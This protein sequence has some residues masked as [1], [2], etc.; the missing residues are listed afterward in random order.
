MNQQKIF[1]YDEELSLQLKLHRERFELTLSIFAK[2]YIV[3]E[4]RVIHADF[5]DMGDTVYIAYVIF[6]GHTNI[7]K[8]AELTKRTGAVRYDTALYG[9]F[10]NPLLMWF[11]NECLVFAEIYTD[12]SKFCCIRQGRLFDLSAG[13]NNRLTSIIDN[14]DSLIAVLDCDHFA[15]QTEPINGGIMPFDCTGLRIKRKPAL[16]T[17]R[18]KNEDE[19]GKPIVG[20]EKSDTDAFLEGGS[21]IVKLVSFRGYIYAAYMRFEKFSYVIK[22]TDFGK[23]QVVVD[24]HRI[25]RHFDMYIDESTKEYVVKSVDATYRKPVLGGLELEFLVGGDCD[26][27]DCKKAPLGRH[28]DFYNQPKRHKTLQHYW[29]DLRVRTDISINSHSTGWHCGSPDD[30]FMEVKHL[31]GLDFCA[32]S[33]VDTHIENKHWDEIRF[34]NEQYNID[35]E[36]VVFNAYEWSLTK[37]FENVGKYNVIFRGRGDIM[38]GNEPGSDSIDG[39]FYRLQNPM[40]EGL[41]V[42]A[43]PAEKIRGV[44]WDKFPKNSVPLVEMF[45]AR[46][47]FESEDGP[48]NPELYNRKIKQESLLDKAL[49]RFPLGFVGGG[50]HEGVG[51]T[52]ILS[53]ELTRE[54]LY[55]ALKERKCY[56]TTGAKIKLNLVVNGVLMGDFVPHSYDGYKVSISVEAEGNID[57]VEIVTNRNIIPIDFKKNKAKAS[58]VVPPGCN[59]IYLRVSQEDTHMAWS[60]PVYI[61]R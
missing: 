52:C 40:R 18:F 10:S 31:N 12:K 19:K 21:E 60:T 37:E 17:Y 46:G 32:L 2:S 8:L 3:D 5:M 4:G 1:K 35:H 43:D 39:L 24:T 33:D 14:G 53:D 36:F 50:G 44:N 16:M 29:G 26:L 6:L 45:N 25:V 30:K 55:F 61:K 28:Q 23:S 58:L 7:I 13:G 27:M 51:L 42:V 11:Q 54:G 47:C 57:T 9:K 48:H 38:R 22:V 15:K 59:Y 20:M 49:L 41:I 56:A 34:R